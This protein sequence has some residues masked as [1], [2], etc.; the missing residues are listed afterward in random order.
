M[1]STGRPALMSATTVRWPG[2]IQK[3]TLALMDVASIAP[4]SRNAAWPGKMWQASQAAKQTS[5]STSAPTI[6]SP[7]SRWANTRQMP[8]YSS[9]NTTRNARAAAIAACGCSAWG[10][11][12]STR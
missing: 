7:R 9:Q 11:D 5:S 4:I 1:G 6:A 10:L 12:G 8:S 2:M 3:N